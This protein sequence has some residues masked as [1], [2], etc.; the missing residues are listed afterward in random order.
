MTDSL[1]LHCAHFL[2]GKTLTDTF[3]W[4]VN[5]DRH[6]I[7][8]GQLYYW[9]WNILTDSSIKSVNTFPMSKIALYTY[10]KRGKFRWAK[11]L[12]CPHYMDFRGYTFVVQGHWHLF[13]ILRAEYSWQNFRGP[14]KNRE[15]LA[16]RNFPRLRYTI[17]YKSFE[18]EKSFTVFQ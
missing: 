12:R 18:G 6:M 8:I 13:L 2:M 7:I 1:P 5:I 11:L 9:K 17:T 15:S 4:G 10:R 16:Q 14:L 3:H